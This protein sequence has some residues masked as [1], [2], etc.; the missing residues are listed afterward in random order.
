MLVA[1]E[2][3]RFRIYTLGVLASQPRFERCLLGSSSA[4]DATDAAAAA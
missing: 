1:R 2:S 4:A 3:G